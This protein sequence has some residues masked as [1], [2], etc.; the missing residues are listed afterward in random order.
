LLKGVNM[1]ASVKVIEFAIMDD[2]YHRTAAMLA[3]TA[4]T[5][6]TLDQLGQGAYQNFQEEALHY[7]GHANILGGQK[8][9]KLNIF[10]LLFR[11]LRHP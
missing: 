10:L 9:G 4:Q 11:L 7:H 6:T 1:I 8:L 5:L 2:V 3:V